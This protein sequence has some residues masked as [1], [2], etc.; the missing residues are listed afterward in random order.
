[1]TALI[2][3]FAVLAVALA[4]S[5]A[6]VGNGAASSIQ[7][8]ETFPIET[9]LDNPDIPEAF[10]VWVEMIDGAEQSLDF[11]EFYV[12][13]VDDSRLAGVLAAVERAA[14]RGVRVRFLSER[15]FYKTYPETL[16]HLGTID[17]IDVRIFDTG[18]FMGGVLHA[19]Y[20]IVDGREAYVGSQNFD[21]RALEHIQELGVR[22]EEPSFVA[23]LA[24]IFGTD[25]HL[26]SGDTRPGYRHAWTT[27][28]AFPAAVD[29]NGE[30]VTIE[31]AFSPTGWLPDEQD[32]DLP[33]IV[34]LIDSAETSVQVQL[35]NYKAVDRDKTY[36]AAL[37]SALRGAAAR[38]VSV[39]LLMSHWSQG[40]GTIQGL[41]S[42]QI[43][44]GIDVKLMTIPEWS[45]G[46]IPY[47]RVIH[48]KYMVVDGVSAWLGTSNWQGD[49]FFKSRNAGLIAHGAA[50]A[51]RLQRYFENGWESEYAATV[52][53][54]KEYA[55][56]RVG[57]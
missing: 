18:A 38:G 4:V 23:R 54:C 28:R 13:D 10:Q 11:A 19:K 36:F 39:K 42:L 32:W 3:A 30:K 48:S 31:P 9:S 22:I 51:G 40:R 6:I 21:W 24:E 45:G 17:N 41:Q 43:I 26:A 37:E 29:L 35:L 7:L 50:F 33:K 15:N 16:D 52:D 34:A 46:F 25:W 55:A 57:R 5:A 12:S 20:F 53:V 8:V 44:P 14:A 47:A 1:M 56:P 49:Y 2:R 27:P